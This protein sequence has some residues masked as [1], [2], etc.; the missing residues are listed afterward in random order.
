MAAV[1]SKGMAGAAGSCTTSATVTPSASAASGPID[2][3]KRERWDALF[4]TVPK[5][6]EML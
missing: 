3:Q 1:Q 4:L 2:A 5:V 6:A